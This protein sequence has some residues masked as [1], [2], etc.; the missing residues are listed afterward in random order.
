MK[1]SV[2][3]GKDVWVIEY[4]LGPERGSDHGFWPVI[5]SR[6]GD[7]QREWY[8]MKNSIVGNERVFEWVKY[9]RLTIDSG[10]RP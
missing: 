7:A 2:L 4:R 3:S 6:R 10:V 8:H 1:R 5:Y 9:R